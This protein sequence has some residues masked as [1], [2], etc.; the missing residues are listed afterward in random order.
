MLCR[1]CGK[2]IPEGSSFCNICGASQKPPPPHRPKQRGNG[3]GT[4]I[5][6]PNGKYKAVVVLEYFRKENGKMGRKL[7]T[8]TCSRKSD[9][10]AALP[11]LRKE[12]P[13]K[14]EITLQELY[15]IYTKTTD[16]ISLSHSQQD[17]LEYA[18]K[19][20]KPLVRRTIDSLTVEEMQDVIDSA[21]QT[22]YPA[23]DM[24]VMLSHLYELAKK[25]EYVTYNKTE[26]LDLPALK[27]AKKDSFTEEEISIFWKDYQEGNAFTGYILVLI[28]TGMRYGELARVKLEDIHPEEQYIRGGIKSAAGRDRIIPLG[29]KILP[30]VQALM[31]GKRKKLLE[32]NED[33]WYKAYWDTI[34]RLKLR[35]LNPHCCRH[36]WFTRMAAAGV[37][38]AL[39]AEAGGHAD[40]NVAYKNYIHTPTKE[41]IA[42]AEKI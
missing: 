5:K 32:M 23:R 18:W 2:E 21:V 7:A 30:V 34:D 13:K 42:A 16:Y 1:K 15:D 40:I 27:K 19:R 33:N 35:R 28:Y 10:V 6:L 3:T 4:V 24:K 9:A 20:L 29:S 41:L 17:K 36:T 14:R 12:K 22:Y 38:P 25:R 31:Q 39:I 8:K 37:P 11:E 26:N